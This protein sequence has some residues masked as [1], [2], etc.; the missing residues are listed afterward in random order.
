MRIDVFNLEKEME[1]HNLDT[2]SARA[3]AYKKGVELSEVVLK[4]DELKKAKF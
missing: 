2:T 3:D 1:Q 4:L